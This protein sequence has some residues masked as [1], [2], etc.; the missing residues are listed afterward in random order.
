MIGKRYKFGEKSPSS[1][2]LPLG[3]GCVNQFSL[4]LASSSSI[5]NEAY[6]RSINMNH[7]RL[8]LYYRSTISHFLL[9]LLNPTGTDVGAA[10]PLPPGCTRRRPALAEQRPGRANAMLNRDLGSKITK[11]THAKHVHNTPFVQCFVD[12]VHSTAVTL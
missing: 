5:A 12:K 9:D 2:Y 8:T 11:H 7:D 4:V 3:L 6:P 10:A 1:L